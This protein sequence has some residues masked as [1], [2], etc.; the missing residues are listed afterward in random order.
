MKTL[1]ELSA[2]TPEGNGGDI[3]VIATLWGVDEDEIL[4]IAMRNVRLT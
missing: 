2:F 3:A 4:A 1:C